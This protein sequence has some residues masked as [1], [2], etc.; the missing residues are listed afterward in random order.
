MMWLLTA[1]GGIKRLFGLAA[2]Y[3]WQAA[4]I[5]ALLA[6]GFL[7]GALQQSRA[8]IAKRDATIV[9][10]IKASRE[11]TAAQIAMN[12]AVTDKQTEIAR[13]ADNAP[14]DII[15]RGRAYADSLRGKDYCRKADS[16]AESGAAASGNAASD[17]AVILE[18][19][20]YDIL[21]GNTARLV[22]VKA[23]GDDL[24]AE[25]LAVPVE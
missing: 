19:A 13:K 5:I 9:A 6:C 21:V 22:N 24:I 8:T 7:Y 25:G 12:K 16:P 17:T 20:D 18:R 23:W 4:L 14:T 15:D 2:R 1:W 10:M 11:A 3:P